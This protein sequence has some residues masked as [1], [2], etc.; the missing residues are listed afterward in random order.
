MLKPLVDSSV[1]LAWHHREG[2]RDK[3]T[4][5]TMADPLDSSNGPKPRKTKRKK[6]LRREIP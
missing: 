1:E 2:R 5:Q 3:Q 4:A 6:S